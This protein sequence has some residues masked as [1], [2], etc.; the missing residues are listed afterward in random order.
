MYHQGDVSVM[1]NIIE[2]EHMLEHVQR[3][4][5]QIHT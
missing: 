5:S 4:L 3:G 1:I 2:L